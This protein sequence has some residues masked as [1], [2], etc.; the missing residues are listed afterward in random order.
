MKLT[1]DPHA[2]NG[3]D[4]KLARSFDALKRFSRS[5]DCTSLPY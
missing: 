4:T 5:G 1:I 3:K 2:Q